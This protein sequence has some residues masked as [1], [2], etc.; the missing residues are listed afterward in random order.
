MPGW[1]RICW[2]DSVSLESNPNVNLEVASFKT[3]EEQHCANT[4]SYH[5]PTRQRGIYG[6]PYQTRRL[7]SSLTFRVM[8]THNIEVALS[9]GHDGGNQSFA[10]LFWIRATDLLHDHA[11]QRA[12]R[13]L[14]ACSE[15]A[16]GFRF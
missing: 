5:G 1:F 13:I 16:G 2:R 12:N 15:I 8:K 7:N 14:L 10:N 4:G 3:A 6:A 11:D 9:P